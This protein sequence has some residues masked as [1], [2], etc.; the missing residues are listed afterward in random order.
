MVYLLLSEIRSQGAFLEIEEGKLVIDA[1]SDFP[2]ALIDR[3]R[4]QR[5]QILDYLRSESPSLCLENITCLA[6]GYNRWW[7]RFDHV[8]ICQICHPSPHSK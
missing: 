5:A 3:L 7:V 6:C 2:N 4:E 8:L 1:P